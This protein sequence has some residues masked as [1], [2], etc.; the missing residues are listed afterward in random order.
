MSGSSNSPNRNA[1]DRSSRRDVRRSRRLR[2]QNPLP[3]SGPLLLGESGNPYDSSDSPTDELSDDRDAND[4]R[5]WEGIDRAVNKYNE[6][7]DG[8]DEMISGSDA[9]MVSDSADTDHLLA[10]FI[11]PTT[12]DDNEAPGRVSANTGQD[13]SSVSAEE[14][15]EVIANVTGSDSEQLEGTGEDYPQSAP[16][17][18]TEKGIASFDEASEDEVEIEPIS[19]DVEHKAPAYG[20]SPLF[21]DDELEPLDHS[22]EDCGGPGTDN[23]EQTAPFRTPQEN[24]PPVTTEDRGEREASSPWETVAE[25]ALQ[26]SIRD[27]AQREQSEQDHQ[28]GKSRKLCSL[29]AKG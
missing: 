17:I 26:A 8:D 24:S 23:Q 3:W 29:R 16:G 10:E 7:E 28:E 22:Q 9:D 5:N 2:S 27:Q 25:E 20:G 21:T 1:I 14:G 11:S 6:S 12:Q 4:S 13:S 15:V 19:Q 18:G